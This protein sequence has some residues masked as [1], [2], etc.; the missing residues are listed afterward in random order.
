MEALL[1]SQRSLG[2]EYRVSEKALVMVRRVCGGSRDDTE[3]MEINRAGFHEGMN[4]HGAN[5]MQRWSEC[6]LRS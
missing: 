1:N 5:D 2:L 6:L 4:F 3:V